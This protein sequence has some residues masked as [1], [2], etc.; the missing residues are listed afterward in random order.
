MSTVRR[1][2]KSP[3]DAG[4]VFC[5]MK[6]DHD[7]SSEP[8]NEVLYSG[9]FHYVICGLGAWVPGYILLV[10][11]CHF[12][13]FSLAPDESQRE[14]HSLF[15]N[16]EQ[17]FLSEFGEV[18]IFEHGAIGDKQRAGGCINHAHVHFIARNVDLCRDLRQQFRPIAIQNGG[19]SN[20]YLPRRETPYL[21]V[22]QKDEEA[23]AFLVDRPLVT[24]FLR[25]KVASK[26]RMDEYWDYKLYPFNENI[27]TT[28]T[29][30]RGKIK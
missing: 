20:R 23:Q 12:D 9:H 14:F 6:L 8:T 5:R 21:Y 19:S 7:L 24:Q 16:I 22:K 29:I 2:D 13:N 15:S 1:P 10:T 26:I 25:Q 18:T 27:I 4:C 11:H 28:I 17:L 30:L 3:F